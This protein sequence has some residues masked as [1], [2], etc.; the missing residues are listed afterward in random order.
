M[1]DTAYRAIAIVGAGAI[2]PDA[3]DV[4]AF[5]KNIKA[6]RCSITEVTPDRWDPA[7]YY[8]PDHNA[9]DKTYSKI[10][11]WVRE[12]A[13]EPLKWRMAIPPRVADAMDGAQHWGIACTREA[14]ADYGYPER[15]LNT[16]RTAVIL[17]NAM[18]GERHYMTAMRAHFPEYARELE[19]SASF[20]ALP[21]AVRREI[22]REWRARL[23]DRLPTI[24]EDSMPGELANC[25]AGRIANLYNFHGPNFVC[26]AACASAMAA[27]SAA[28]DGLIEH[29]FDVAVTGGIDRNMGASTFVKF[30][31]I[32]A[33]SGTGSRPYAEGADGFVMGEGAAIILMKRLA[34]AERDGDKIYAVLR[35][36][37][38]AS[39]GKGKGITAPNPIGQKICIERAWENAGLS[40]ATVTLI[41]G[42][43]TST[44]VGDVVEV[45]G[46]ARVLRE[47]AVN[48]RPIALGSVKSNIGH[49]KGA[50]GAAGILKTVLALRDKVLPPSVGCEHPNPNID[51]AHSPLYVNTELRP[52]TE[53]AEGV[54][55]AGVS[56]FGFGGTNFHVVLE[57]YIPHRL[58]G[59][60]KHSVATREVP[61]A[62][63]L[64]AA[65]E[66][67]GVGQ[68]RHSTSLTPAKAPLRGALVTGAASAADLAERLRAVQKAAEAGRTPASSAPSDAD[69][70]AAERIAIDYANAAELADKCAKALKALASD[71]PAVWKALRAQGIFRGHG[72]A[73]KVAFLYTG[74][75]SQYVN[76]LR[77]LRAAEPIVAGTFDEA[78]RVM[79]PLLGKPLSQYIFVD[80]EDG[81]AVAQ[82]EEDLR[83][84]AITQ[85][86]VLAADLS[87][88]RL[89]DAY[90]IRPDM[91]MG[92]SLGEYGALVA[93]GALPF[94]DALE[95]V[96]ARGRE[97]TRVSW[98]DNGRMAAVFAPLAEIE[99]ILKTVDGYVVIANLNSDKQS[100]IGGA[101]PAVELA[102]RA[103]GKAGYDVVPLPV[104]H[105]FHTSIVAPASEPLRRTL[106]RLH[107][108]PAS[109]PVV[110]NVNGEFY[111]A[112]PDARLAMLDILARQVASPVQ[113]I[114]GLRTLYEAG[115]RVFVEVG[116][117]KALFGFVEDVL[118]EHSDVLAL[119]SNHPKFEDAT[120]FNQA[121][122]GLYASGLGAARVEPRVEAEPH[123]VEHRPPARPVVI[124]GASLGLPGTDHIFDDS[125]VARILRGEQF[126][127]TIPTRFRRAMLDKHITRLVKSDNGG[128]TFEQIRNPGDVIKLAARGGAFDLGK[129]FGVKP[130]RIQALD[131]VTSLAIA[132]GIDALRDAGIPLTMRYKSTTT[133]TQLPERWGLPD[134]LRDDTGVI[135]ASVFPGYDSF[136]D[137]MA[138]YYADHAR[139]DQLAV[140]ED[141]RERMVGPNGQPGVRQ[142][143]DRRIADLQ[144]AIA[145]EPFQLDRRFLFRV[146]SM[147]HSQFAELIGARGPNTQINA[148]CASTTQA[149]AVAE[150][151]IRAGRCRRVIVVSADD[152]TSDR[153]IEWFGA[154]FL[155]SGAA[156]TDDVVEEA[157]IPFDRRRHGMIMGMGAAALVLESAEAAEERGLRPI[158]EVLS[159][160]TANSAF[161]GTRLDVHHIHNVM[162]QL[163]RQAET[164]NGIRREQFAPGMLFVS[165]ETYTPARGG[166]ASA[167][168]HALRAVFGDAA[169]K[170][171]IA[172]TKGLTGHAMGTGIE[173]VVA[174]KALETGCVPPVANFK[175]VD[176]ELGPLNLS[177]GGA[178]PVEYALRLGAGFGSQISMTL[179]RRVA[180][181]GARPGPNALGYNYRIADPVV[182]QNWLNQIAGHPAELEIVHRT[183]RVHDG[184]KWDR[185]PG[186]SSESAK[187]PAP[188]PVLQPA[189]DPVRERILALAV[190]KTG[191][192]REMLDLDLDLEADLGVD[193]VK[194]AEMFAAIRES[195]N[196]PRDPDLKLRDFPT[197]AR[198]I[199]FV[200]DRRPDL[201]APRP[202][203]APATVSERTHPQDPVRENVLNLIAGK[204]GYPK[205]MLDLDLDLE[206]DLGVDTVKQAEVFA[207]VRETYNIPRDPN[208]K[209]RDF[210]TL[211]R[212]IQ[213][214]YDRCPD[215]KAPR[216]APAP[217]TPIEPETVTE[218][219]HPEDPI[220]EKVL[221]I[222]AE[223]TG[224]PKEMLD[225]DLDLEADLGIDTVKQAEMFASVRATFSIPRDQALRLRDFPTLAHVIRFAED[226]RVTASAPPVEDQ[227]PEPATFAASDTIP[228]RV[229]IPA[230]RPPLALC[231]PTG[232]SL[233]PGRRVFVMPDNSGVAEALTVKLQALGVE[234]VHTAD[235]LGDAP[236][237]GVYWLP[238]LD[239]EGDL[240][241][242]TLA[243]WREAV[244]RRIK[245][246]YRIMRSL[247]DQVAP[248]G[249]FLISATR[250][251]GQHG[252]DEAGATAPLGGSVTG[253]TKAYKR[254]RPDALVKAVDFETGRDAAEIAGLLI[255]ETLRDPGAIEIG[256]QNSQRW[257]V[258]LEERP[259]ADGQPGMT[260]DKDSVFLV[261]GAAG[262]IVSAITADLAAAS[263][264]TFYLL[265][266]VPEPDAGDPDLKRF[267]TDKEALKRDLFARIQARGERATPALV[268]KELASLERAKAAR[269]AIDAV[270]AAGGTAHYRSVNLTDGD[271]VAK[272]I[273][274]VRQRSGRIDVLLHAA[275]IDRSHALPDKDPREFDLVFD[276]KSDGLFHLLHAIGDMPLAAM[277][278]FSSIAGRFGNGGQT[279]YSS[280][281]DLICKIASS[282]RRTRTATRAIA[283]DWTAWGGIGMAT[284]GSIP[285]VMEM[286]GIDMLPP[287][288]GVPWIRRELTTGAA[289]GEVVVAGRLGALLKEWDATGGL[290]ASAMPQGPMAGGAARMDLDGRVTIETPLDP[291]LQ[292]FL[293]DHR[294]DGTPVLPG[295]MGIEGF[296]EAALSVAPGWHVEAVEDIDFLTPFK[297]YR[298]EPRPI[299]IEA[300]FRPEDD[301]L[302]ADCR[303]TGRR[304][305]AN[306][307]EARV[308]THFTGRVRLATQLPEIASGPDPGA[309]REWLIN[310]EDIYR[311]YFH[312][313]AYR[314][315]KRARWDENGAV[316]E[317]AAGLPDNHHP[318]EQPLKIAPRLIE[319]CFQT[320]GLWE[321][322]IQHRMGLPRHVDRVS[323]YRP[324]E[325]AAG[326]LFAVVTANPAAGSF[327]A[328]V[329]D[330]AGVRYL[331]VGGYRT[332]VFR[333]GVDVPALTPAHAAMA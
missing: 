194:Q 217:A 114:K 5:W 109:V 204:T 145:K 295:V 90:G 192:P 28:A 301:A 127:D 291:A 314:V 188:P 229:P 330:S 165:H 333:E 224:Y 150:D 117:K 92:H 21:A 12:Y 10:G 256:Y 141:L 265:D 181:A 36:V 66:G 44:S 257:T 239:D 135:F 75:G 20:A 17:G 87:L 271:A 158:C 319:L 132:A 282:F 74:Q 207:A 186:L 310:A 133:G 230:L 233:E 168:I 98:E 130:E 245:S 46:M 125:N 107:L 18:A 235:A 272:V 302:A 50:A 277:I 111:P 269:D 179:L 312:G 255:D 34:D 71:Q 297:F 142:E 13:W 24:T 1:T 240:N 144:E 231:K 49:L 273:A 177:K 16:D 88:T 299:T 284:R 162:E 59:N 157:A 54:R 103:L 203:P 62:G 190:E 287:E 166:S 126:I 29:D 322:A 195:Y 79:T 101:S 278:G 106:E 298:G 304:V 281:N 232:V 238:A 280:A 268:E 201:K 154:G 174:V 25:I 208:L 128:P 104:S 39:D 163:V 41:E 234:V 264:G 70:H 32:G 137:E 23:G 189:G 199:Q 241:H 43:G 288:A 94:A 213:F 91:T 242:M 328:D 86:A 139:R 246:F 73:P 121:L 97:M 210:P 143:I 329:V 159:A 95:A 140:L 124:T 211:A 67:L 206:A 198:V 115:A 286:A 169:D 248:S 226:R 182:W 113:F 261:T 306:Q 252:F 63:F 55:R 120:A 294:I 6:G 216:P 136:A 105:A 108:Q 293:D 129:E 279:D 200:Y 236:I 65:P 283:I 296:A 259:A 22:T 215:L 167:E 185:P 249:T 118:G 81:G 19:E 254:E 37:A 228:R 323:L 193:T 152:I 289:R 184:A 221:E 40:P 68:G 172:N 96:S 331:H 7:L 176:P 110:A 102:V 263:G 69:L 85:P 116:P 42:H 315:L 148:A 300:R 321:M 267:A 84:T 26:D 93:A 171:V 153:L 173:D 31:K 72:P 119:F 48:G 45:D 4:P 258:G 308:E 243:A 35:G 123:P 311:I 155:A 320:A 77:G 270:R 227:H 60:G 64:P 209:L 52:W 219:S 326:P 9:P 307:A 318:N 11:G 58:T 2:L 131:R 30:C 178:Y 292:P 15:P 53:T 260:L 122:C 250:L 290:E 99:R 82:A 170:I 78:D 160:A 112:G 187:A 325:A 327:D 309:T 212:V 274:D 180:G 332:V 80:S 202:A 61:P 285:K 316:G 244:D 214:V 76:M 147:G 89:L 247:Y 33:L 324:P 161:H 205:D 218:R 51:F 138:R 56:A 222:V 8:D 38:G 275:G 225:L 197:L 164:R 317:M 183:L 57:E 27:I 175:E 151:W 134:A 276:V 100:V 14:L 237:H 3:P 196:I 156:A 253:F 220:R 47:H 266:L 313:P 149:V 251:G 305:L 83:Q 303:L 191:Y 146:L 262:S 223:K